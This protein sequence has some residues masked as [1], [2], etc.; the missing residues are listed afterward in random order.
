[1][2]SLLEMCTF[3]RLSLNTFINES[4]T[5]DFDKN[6]R[7]SY[8]RTSTQSIKEIYQSNGLEGVEK[9]IVDI[10]SYV[11]NDLMKAD[12]EK[13]FIKFIKNWINK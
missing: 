4:S 3:P 6:Y 2:K 12:E 13:E 7:E 1:M 9:H 5:F 8:K 10:L 11:K